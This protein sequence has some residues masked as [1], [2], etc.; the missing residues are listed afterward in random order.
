MATT[1]KIKVGVM[2]LEIQAKNAGL[3]II[4]EKF[5]TVKVEDSITVKV[6]YWLVIKDY[7]NFVKAVS[8]KGVA[9]IVINCIT[10]VKKLIALIKPFIK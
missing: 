5:T 1:L 4:V 8:V 9:I 10:I 7:I 6:N 3:E 2:K